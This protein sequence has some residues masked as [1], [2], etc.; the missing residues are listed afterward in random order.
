[1]QRS[2]IVSSPAEELILVDS[3]DRAIG[4]MP[5][6]DCHAGAGTLHRA[7]SIFLFSTEGKVLLQRRGPDKPLWPRFWSNAC[8]SHPRSGEAIEEALHRRLREELGADCPLT[9]LFKFEYRA[10]FGDVGAEHELCSVFIGVTDGPFDPNRSELEDLR[11]F[12][13]D[14]LE[15]RLAADPEAFTPWFR[16]EWER[17][18][19][20]LAAHDGSAR[21]LIAS[22]GRPSV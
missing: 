5:K 15:A 3:G 22:Q 19:S 9:F 4:A 14:E 16:M 21:S 10:Q 18:E 13:R 17:I 6:K 7:F 1:M 8:C 11:F 12:G 2:E 20:V